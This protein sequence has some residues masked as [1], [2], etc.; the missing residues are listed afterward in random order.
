MRSFWFPCYPPLEPTRSRLNHCKFEKIK[1]PSKGTLWDSAF[2][3]WCPF[4]LLQLRGNVA[5]WKRISRVSLYREGR[6]G[7]YFTKIF[8][9]LDFY[10][11]VGNVKVVG[12][13]VTG[14]RSFPNTHRLVER[15]IRSKYRHHS[16]SQLYTKNSHEQ[17]LCALSHNLWTGAICVNSTNFPIHMIKKKGKLF[18]LPSSTV[19]SNLRP[20]L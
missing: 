18:V 5:A 9:V 8:T 19:L 20:V 10:F 2:L 6:M 4:C 13:R 12:Y 15:Q 17:I 7:C 11:S 14:S 3:C 16:F 1:H